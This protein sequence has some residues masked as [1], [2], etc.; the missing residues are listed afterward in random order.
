MSY[1]VWDCDNKEKTIEFFKNDIDALKY[2]NELENQGS[3]VVYVDLP[4]VDYRDAQK[5]Y[6]ATQ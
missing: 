2:K 4:A 3:E 5:I 6:F 1:I